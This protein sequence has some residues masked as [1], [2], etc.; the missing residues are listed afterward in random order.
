MIQGTLSVSLDPPCVMFEP[1]VGDRSSWRIRYCSDN[2]LH[3]V[4]SDLGVEQWPL[5]ECFIRLQGRFS[6]ASLLRMGLNSVTH[7]E[8]FVKQIKQPLKA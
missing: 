6:R 7:S 8:R 2:E 5:R 1:D 3:Q 4:L